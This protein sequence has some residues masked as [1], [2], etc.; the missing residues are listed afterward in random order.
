MRVINLVK[1]IGIGLVIYAATLLLT[2]LRLK[3]LA[4]QAHGK[5]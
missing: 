1:W 3:H 2:G 5:I 4:G